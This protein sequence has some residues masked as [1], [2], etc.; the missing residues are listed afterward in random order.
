MRGSGFLFN[1]IFV[2]AI[3]GLVKPIYIFGVDRNVQLITGSDY[4]VY[5]TFFSLAFILNILSDM[6]M[7]NFNLQYSSQQTQ[8]IQK[9]FQKFLSIKMLLGAIYFSVYLVAGFFHPFTELHQKLFLLVGASLWLNA[10]LLFVRSF[11]AAQG[12]YMMDSLLS[13][14]DK[15]LMISI[16][17][18]WIW[19]GHAQYQLDIT[20]FVWIQIFS[21]TIAILVGA[22][23]LSQ[24]SIKIKPQWNVAF[25]LVI[26]KRSLPFAIV[27]I[28]MAIYA[29]IDTLMLSWMM[30]DGAQAVE[31][32]AES[33][34]ILEALNMFGYLISGLLLPMFSKNIKVGREQISLFRSALGLSGM[35]AIPLGIVFVIYADP[36]MT[37]LYHDADSGGIFQWHMVA[38]V[39]NTLSYVFGTYITA[40]GQIH[41]LNR[42]FLIGCLLNVLLNIWIIPRYGAMGTAFT[43][44][45]T[46]LLIFGGQAYYARQHLGLRLPMGYGSKLFLY[47]VVCIAMITALSYI[48]IPW[49]FNATVMLMLCFV[50]SLILKIFKPIE[51]IKLFDSKLE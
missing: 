42:L 7:Q 26:L 24:S 43:S 5:Y 41:K 23:V 34:R 17:G 30:Q 20:D 47:L 15:A 36:F 44:F 35:V 33:Y 6:G 11:I 16:L 19:I 45:I 39:V 9:N 28:L 8:L 50:F 10:L 37:L 32:Y 40:H 48:E 21:Y 13:A 51:A 3:N 2:L 49:Y 46:Q 29:R 31:G 1:V 12:K 38:F 14:L 22:V 25:T 4:G 18:S 27:I